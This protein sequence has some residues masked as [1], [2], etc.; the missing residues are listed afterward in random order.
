[1]DHLR[2][3]GHNAKFALF[4][5]LILPAYIYSDQALCSD[6]VSLKMQ[7]FQKANSKAERETRLSMLSLQQSWMN[8]L[9]Y[10]THE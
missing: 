4:A 6:T 2:K 9:K 7:L 5:E 1:M 8:S 10:L 3:R